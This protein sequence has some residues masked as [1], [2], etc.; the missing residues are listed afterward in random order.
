MVDVTSP[1]ISDISI[2]SPDPIDTESGFG[3]ENFTC[4]VTDN[5]DVGN[6]FINITCPGSSTTNV[7]MTKIGGTDQYYYNTTLS[8][9]NYTY[10]IWANDTSDNTDTSSNYDLSVSPNW[11]MNHDGV[12]NLLDQ[13]FISNHYGE[14]SSPGWIREDIDNNGQIQVLDLVMLSEHYGETWWI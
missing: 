1:E 13:V 5:V 4:T 10:F 14:I 3:W 12:C 8:H 7:S 6:V 9:G 2:S 11:D